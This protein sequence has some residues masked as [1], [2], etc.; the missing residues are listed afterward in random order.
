M[1]AECV[2]YTFSYSHTTHLTCATHLKAL[3]AEQTEVLV[4]FSPCLLRLVEV[5][6][7]VYLHLL[8]AVKREKQQQYQT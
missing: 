7:Q 3:Y 2:L 5:F 1:I 4:Q 6:F 8:S